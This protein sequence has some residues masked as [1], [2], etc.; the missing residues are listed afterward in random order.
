MNAQTLTLLNQATTMR[1]LDR[2]RARRAYLA[3]NSSEVAKYVRLT[4]AWELKAR[5]FAREVGTRLV[6][7]PDNPNALIAEV[8]KGM[9]TW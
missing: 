8:F 2:N 4:L 6:P 5:H 7:M 1:N 3:G 9:F